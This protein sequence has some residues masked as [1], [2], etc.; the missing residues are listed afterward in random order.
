MTSS[1]TVE[2][3]GPGSPDRDE[4]P[5]NR[6]ERR[7][8]ALLGVPT[9]ALALATTV[10][11][12]YLPVVA[13]DV[14]GSTLVI[15]LIIGIEGFMALWLP[16]VVGS[17]SDR[18]DTR[19]GGRLPF[20]VVGAPILAAGLVALG[21]VTSTLT[22][23]L[24]ALVFF[25]GYF[26]AYEPYRALYPDAVP[27]EVAGRAQ[28]TQ[29]AFRGAGTGLA[30]LTGGALLG[31]GTATPF[32]VAAVVSTA[33]IAAF[34]AY[35]VR[36]GVP[37]RPHND[38][39][40]IG[41]AARRVAS[42]I[43]RDRRLRAF[44]VANGLWELALGA[45]KTFIVLYVSAGLGFGRATSGLLIGG[46]AVLVLLASLA[47]GKL[48]DRY[49]RVHVMTYAV[50]LFGLGLV[51]V[52]LSSNHIVIAAAIPFVAAGGG[53]LMALPYALL[54]PLMPEEEHGVL[55][56]YYS[57]SRGF[58]TWMGPLLAGLSITTLG[59]AFPDTGGYQAMW[60]PVILAT[61]LSLVPLRALGRSEAD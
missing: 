55:S 19:I 36:R 29:A 6:A 59:G 53:A 41:Q 17:W 56:G 15:G 43:Q 16:L 1:G 27:D 7:T 31:L 8:V 45:L 48:A 12:T 38:D 42:V 52:L 28:S 25:A 10:V 3:S 30:L 4:R 58:G 49:G 22:V 2:R 37:D 20:L 11:T 50:A 35:V 60:L 34:V 44:A 40:T 46:V 18:L 24:A 57:F 5:M 23:A 61:L 33:A 32:V 26:L 14:I 13:S 54:M 47:C 51:P 39:A 21:L 9:L